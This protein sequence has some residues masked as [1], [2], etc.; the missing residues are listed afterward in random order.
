MQF[1][2]TLWAT[3]VALPLLATLIGLGV[4]QLQRLEWK[5]GLIALRAERVVSPALDLVTRS[6]LDRY[7]DRGM[8]DLR[9]PP[10]SGI[11]T[12]AADL[13]TFE[14]RPIRVAGRFQH[15]RTLRLVSRTLTGHVGEHVV[16]PLELVQGGILLVD[17]GW[18]PPRSAAAPQQAYK[19]PDGSVVV[20]GYIRRFE[21][22]GTFTPDNAPATDN[23]YWLD[24]AGVGASLGEDIVADFYVQAAPG[25]PDALP[26][27]SIPEVALN[28]P[29]L[30]Y[31]LTW[32]G[33]AATLVG[34]WVAFHVKRR[35]P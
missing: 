14:Y 35:V 19:R 21:P 12:I 22:P 28:N 30:G 1:R 16:T 3:L 17:R 27:G 18:V 6:R 13:A 31:A 15:D 4:W 23:W 34:V 20:E 8:F 24:P 7:T 5:E 32:F 2:P 11:A 25:D 29:H 10:E 9:L 26:Y 33:L